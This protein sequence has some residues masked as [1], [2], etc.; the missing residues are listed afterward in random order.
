MRTPDPPAG[1]APQRRGRRLAGGV[2]PI[3]AAKRASADCP[4]ALTGRV[5]MRMTVTPAR[6]I[7]TV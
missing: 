6:W 2:M 7:L 1:L 3:A 4:A 5:H